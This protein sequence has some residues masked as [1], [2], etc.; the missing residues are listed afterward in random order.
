[1]PEAVWVL[2]V[3]DFGPLIVGMDAKGNPIYEKVELE[4]ERNAAKVKQML[5]I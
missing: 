5:G 3:K 2:E 1:M 4:V